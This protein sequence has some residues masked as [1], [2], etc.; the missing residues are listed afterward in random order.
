MNTRR[1][2][3]HK[4]GSFAV[5]FV[6]FAGCSRQQN[7]ASS[8]PETYVPQDGSIGFEIGPESSD[9]QRWSAKYKEGGKV[10]HFHI[11]LAHDRR[12]GD[13]GMTFGKGRFIAE[14][15]SDASV[16]L[17]KLKNVLE[18]KNLPKNVTRADSLPFEFVTLGEKMSRSATGSFSDEPQ[19][20]WSAFKIF[21]RN[22]EAEVYMNLN[23][24]IGKGEFSIKDSDYG[25]AVLA[26][27]AKVL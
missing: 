6:L 18:A 25:D 3:I 26:E 12:S 23:P 2:A 5:L 22:G 19:G 20:N 15:D 13:Y 24:A 27:L 9:S 21:L 1:M 16:F 7:K 17:A 14:R 4:L 8:V 10:S 11:E